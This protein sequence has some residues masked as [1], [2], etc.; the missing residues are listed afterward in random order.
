MTNLFC[1]TASAALMSLGLMALSACETSSVALG[2]PVTGDFLTGDSLEQFLS[3]K[4]L[5]VPGSQMGFFYSPD[6]KTLSISSDPLAGV[7]E[8]TM[9]DGAFCSREDYY[10]RDGGALMEARNG[11]CFI[12]AIQEDGSHIMYSMLSGQTAA[13]PLGSIVEGFPRMTEYLR[14]VDELDL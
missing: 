3:G 7:G 10:Y 12:L 4:Y 9:N 5:F 11:D 1:K 2:E 13:L 8:W 14:L 6:G